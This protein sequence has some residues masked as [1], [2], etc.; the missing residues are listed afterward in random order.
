MNQVVYYGLRAWLWVTTNCCSR[1]QTA[2]FIPKL[3]ESHWKYGNVFDI[4]TLEYSNGRTK[5]VVY[6]ASASSHKNRQQTI[7]FVPP[8]PPPPWFFIGCYDSAKSLQDKTY[9]MDDY[10]YPG[11]TITLELLQHLFPGSQRWVYIHPQ[12][13]EETEFP[14]E[15]I[16][17]E[18]DEDGSSH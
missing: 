4:Q 16:V 5:R 18:S 7:R 14:S 12:T 9:E 17:I 2:T 10:V 8:T 13:F 3:P 11:N 1:K 6:P 15:G